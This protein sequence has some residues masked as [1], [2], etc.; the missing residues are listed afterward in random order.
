MVQCF[1][2]IYSR[3]KNSKKDRVRSPHWGPLSEIAQ[4]IPDWLWKLFRVFVFEFYYSSWVYAQKWFANSLALSHPKRIQKLLHHRL[5]KLYA[6]HKDFL[7]SVYPG[8]RSDPGL[9]VQ[10][11]SYLPEHFTPWIAFFFDI[12]F[13]FACFQLNFENIDF[14]SICQIIPSLYN[15]S[16][17]LVLIT[18][19]KYEKN[20]DL[21]LLKSGCTELR[22]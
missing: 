22:F 10:I 11:V 2:N 3:Q 20:I 7:G 19:L 18:I 6:I 21:W 1:F 15:F 5:I 9:G 17:S 13:D 4:N 12:H 8:D 14:L 16:S